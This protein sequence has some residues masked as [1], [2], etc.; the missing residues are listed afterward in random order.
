MAAVAMPPASIWKSY[1]ADGAFCVL[2]PRP[3][4]K[5]LT[6]AATMIV[7][8]SMSMT[9]TTGETPPSSKEDNSE[10]FVLIS[11]YIAI[12]ENYWMVMVPD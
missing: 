9:P 11:L 5:P 2:S 7:T 1:A 4:A 8:T 12:S 6:T 10:I 3:A